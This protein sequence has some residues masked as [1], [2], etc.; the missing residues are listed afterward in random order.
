M[1]SNRVYI[2]IYIIIYRGSNRVYI[3]IYIASP[4]GRVE[5]ENNK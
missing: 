1:G 3:Y 4:I 2:Y 5:I